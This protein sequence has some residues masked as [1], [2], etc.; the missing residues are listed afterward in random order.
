MIKNEHYSAILRKKQRF[1]A[2]DKE[3]VI[4]FKQRFSIWLER[5]LWTIALNMCIV[6]LLIIADNFLRW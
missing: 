5:V 3:L 4:G 6:Y 1:T 2:K